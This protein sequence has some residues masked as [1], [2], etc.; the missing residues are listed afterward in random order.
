MNP[1][2]EAGL[3]QASAKLQA[4]LPPAPSIAIP[5]C[6]DGAAGRSVAVTTACS[7]LLMVNRRWR[8]HQHLPASKR[9]RR[10]GS[11][12]SSIVEPQRQLQQRARGQAAKHRIVTSGVPLTGQRHFAALPG[13]LHLQPVQ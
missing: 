2:T 1:Y 7:L 12:P 11:Y 8:R 5:P 13:M 10:L 9:L 6:D 4:S 3:K